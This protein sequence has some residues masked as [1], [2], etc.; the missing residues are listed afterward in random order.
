MRKAGKWPRLIVITGERRVE[1]IE[2]GPIPKR[3]AAGGSAVE[4]RITQERTP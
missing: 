4:A 3:A 1:A 2:Q